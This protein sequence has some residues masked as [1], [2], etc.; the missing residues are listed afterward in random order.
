M[1]KHAVKSKVPVPE[2]SSK[3]CGPSRDFFTLKS[4]GGEST[5]CWEALGQ[6][7]GGDSGP[8]PVGWGRGRPQAVRLRRWGGGPHRGLWDRGRTEAVW[9][10]ICGV[11]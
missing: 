4:V 10:A 3:T 8:R 1:A 11:M 7:S 6:R 9:G 5:G 2:S